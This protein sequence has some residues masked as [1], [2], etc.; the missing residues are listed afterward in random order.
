MCSSSLWMLEL[1]GPSSTTCG[2]TSA[3]KRASEVP[4]VVESS[5][6]RPVCFLMTVETT[7]T[8]RPRD[9]M[10]GF[11]PRVHRSEEHTSELQS[12]SDLVCR[13]LLE[14]KKKPTI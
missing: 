14:K 3:M 5:G 12:R 8:S 2:Q 9:V 13:L 7:S 10:N 6:A 11:A 1:T 4:P